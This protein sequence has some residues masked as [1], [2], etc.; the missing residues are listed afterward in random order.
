MTPQENFDEQMR[1][2]KDLQR[3][4]RLYSNLAIGCAAVAVTLQLVSLVL[5]HMGG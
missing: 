3:K 5:R 2:I 1:K 4:S